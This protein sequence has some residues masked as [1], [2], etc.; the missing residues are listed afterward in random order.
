MRGPDGEAGAWASGEPFRSLPPRPPRTLPD[1]SVLVALL[2]AARSAVPREL[3]EQFTALLRELLLAL[4]GMID[5]YLERLG[6]PPREK[7][8]E[9]IPID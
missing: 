3:Q 4:R 5:S 9:D 1:L 8:V 2:D 6:G 7:R